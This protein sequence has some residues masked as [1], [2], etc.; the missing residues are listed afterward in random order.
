[1]SMKNSSDAIGNRTLEF[2]ACSTV[3][4]PTAAPRNPECHCAARNLSERQQ[5]SHKP[6]NNMPD[7]EQNKLSEECTAGARKKNEN[8]IEE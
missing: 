6:K 4:Q 3:L 8:N 1:M 5:R 2:L 7:L